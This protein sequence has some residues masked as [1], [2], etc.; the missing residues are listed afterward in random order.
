MA[1]STR[2]AF[3]SGLIAVDHTGFAVDIPIWSTRLCR[4]EV[5]SL[6]LSFCWPLIYTLTAVV[7]YSC[8]R[9]YFALLI[10]VDTPP[11]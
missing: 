11:R 6:L 8:A 4:P 9:D 7:I 2:S 3:A 1:V 10:V 5:L